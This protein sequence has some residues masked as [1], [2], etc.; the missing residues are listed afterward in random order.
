MELTL[1]R[2]QIFERLLE[3][4]RMKLLVLAINEDAHSVFPLRVQAQNQ[5]EINI[6]IT[7]PLRKLVQKV[8]FRA[9]DLVY[10][11]TLD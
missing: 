2:A 3:P 10:D 5:A 4:Q 9:I 7:E 6:D 8:L 1:T 11:E